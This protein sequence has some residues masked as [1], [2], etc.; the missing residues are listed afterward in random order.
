M[1]EDKILSVRLRITTP[2][3]V[4]V[5]YLVG[6]MVVVLSLCTYLLLNMTI[7]SVKNLWML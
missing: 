5:R 1:I 7:S 2:I 3:Y 4:I 6:K